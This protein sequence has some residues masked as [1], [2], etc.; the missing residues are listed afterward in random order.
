MKQGIGKAPKVFCLLAGIL[1][2]QMAMVSQ[3][4]AKGGRTTAIVANSGTDGQAVMDVDWSKAVVESTMKRNPDPPK[5]GRWQ[6]PQALYLMGQFQLWQRTKDPRYFDYMK[7]WVDSHVDDSGNID[8]PIES[9]DNMLPGN[10]LLVLYQETKQEKYKLAAAKVRERLNTYPRTKDGGFWH[11]N[12]E[13]HRSQLW[14]DGMYMSMPFLVRYGNAFN[15]GAYANDEAAKQILIYASHLGDPS[16]GLLYHAYDETGTQS[17][18]DPQTHHSAEFWCRALGWYGMAIV[19]ILDVLPANHPKRPQLI[20]ILQ[21]LIK[22]L[23]KYQDSKTG[24]WYQIV[25]KGT[26]PDNWLETSSSSMYSYTILTAVKKGYVDKSYE[27]VAWKGYH[28]VLTKISLGPDGMTTLI[29][30]CEG[31]NLG[32]QA[33]VLSGAEAQHQ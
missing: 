6:Y 17:W 25:D 12:D 33:G 2:V 29:D 30:I 32:D 10:L 31:T 18:A 28:G 21:K 26:L 19:D 3:A 5:L 7:S 9:L 11:A 8:R 1:L 16:Q 4:N 20:A 22:D 23:A 13:V 15:D 24:L 14:L 27:E